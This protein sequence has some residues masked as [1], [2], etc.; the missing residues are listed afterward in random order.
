MSRVGLRRAVRQFAQRA[1]YDINYYDASNS[2]EAA[3]AAMIRHH[4]VTLVLDVGANCGQYGRK[5]RK[6]G[7]AG[8]I[9][10]FEPLPMAY[11]QLCRE[12]ERDELWTVAPRLA[13]A[14]YDGEIEINV[15]GDG[16]ASSSALFVL[17]IVAVV[18]P[19]TA[20]IGREI[21]P[22]KK[23]DSVAEGFQTAGSILLKL[24]V[25]GFEGR[26]LDGAPKLLRRVQ[27]VQLEMSLVPLYERAD[28]WMALTLRLQD[29]GFELWSVGPAFTDNRS[30]RM[31]ACD[32]F[33]FRDQSVC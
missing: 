14:D 20:Y 5:V 27:G 25:Q 22:C 15:A 29:L 23:L 32:G 13:I 12:A 26:V 33:F 9:I 3:L 16:G 31:L 17:P 11:Q 24:D 2:H 21:V 10:S 6:I 1:G 19:N 7:Y 4:Q 28:N 18:E 8:R 30:G